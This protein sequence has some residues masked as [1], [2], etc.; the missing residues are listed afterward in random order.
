MRLTTVS[1]VLG[2]LLAACGV[3][4]PNDTARMPLN[5]FGGPAMTQNDAISFAG[6]AL[7]H[8]EYTHDNPARA[9]RAIAAE[10]W[11]AGQW[12]LTPDYGAYGPVNEWQWGA[13]RREVRAAI[14]VSPQTPS[15]VLI[16][17]LL[18]AEA[19][20]NKGNTDAARAQLQ[21]PVFSNGPDGTLAALSNLPKFGDLENAF[22]DL[23]RNQNRIT[24]PCPATNC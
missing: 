12:Q 9:A 13:L 22:N 11:L 1:V 3:I 7:R 19:A 8:P 20:L 4:K 21:P 24:G 2:A 18:M 23:R 14:G 5:E 6:Y 16:D 15:Q 17:H 10:D